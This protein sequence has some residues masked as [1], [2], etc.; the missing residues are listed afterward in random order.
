MDGA[1]ASRPSVTC[2]I[3]RKDS[4]PTPSN[5]FGGWRQGRGHHR[6]ES[7]RKTERGLSSLDQKYSHHVFDGTVVPNRRIRISES[8]VAEFP[9]RPC[10]TSSSYPIRLGI[11]FGMNRQKNRDSD[12]ELQS[13]NNSWGTKWAP[14]NWNFRRTSMTLNR[15]ERIELCILLHER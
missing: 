4:P 8:I 10:P 3:Y 9:L 12:K 14:A 6:H 1:P 2:T 11:Q 13:A 5:R 15:P 7:I